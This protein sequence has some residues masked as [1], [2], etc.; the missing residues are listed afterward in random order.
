MNIVQAIVTPAEREAADIAK[1]YESDGA[2]A[3][4]RRLN[5]VAARLNFSVGEYDALVHVVTC[6]IRGK[7]WKKGA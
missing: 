6:M 1:L 7:R 4:R 2:V 3:A 5:E